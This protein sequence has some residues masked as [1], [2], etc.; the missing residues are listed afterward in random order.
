V[1]VFGKSN[2]IDSFFF[3]LW[4]LRLMPEFRH[5]CNNDQYPDANAT[6]LE[7]P[8]IFKKEIRD[9]LCEIVAETNT[10]H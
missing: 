5:S 8:R 3:L 4:S 7:H 9:C 2:A 1:Y 10:I 6:Q